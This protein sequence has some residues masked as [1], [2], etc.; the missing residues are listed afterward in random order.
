MQAVSPPVQEALKGTRISGLS[1]QDAVMIRVGLQGVAGLSLCLKT[2]VLAEHYHEHLGAHGN[3]EKPDNDSGLDVAVCTLLGR[4][5]A[6]LLLGIS[7]N[8][9]D[10][11]A[12]RDFVV[13]LREKLCDKAEPSDVMDCFCFHVDLTAGDGLAY[14]DAC[15]AALSKLPNVVAG[16]SAR[17]QANKYKG[18]L[19]I[20]DKVFG[21]VYAFLDGP[22]LAAWMA[23]LNQVTVGA[24]DRALFLED[25]RDTMWG[26]KGTT[27]HRLARNAL[28]LPDDGGENNAHCLANRMQQASAGFTV[29]TQALVD[30]YTQRAPANALQALPALQID[31]A[32]CLEGSKNLFA[33]RG[34]QLAID[35]NVGATNVFSVTLG[36]R[37]DA[38]KY[39][40]EQTKRQD[41]AYRIPSHDASERVWHDWMQKIRSLPQQFEIDAAT[42]I[43]YTANH[44]PEHDRIM[45]GWREQMVKLHQSRQRVTL[46]DFFAHVRRA[47]FSSPN[48]RRDAAKQLTS[49]HAMT[50]T[51]PDCHAFVLAVQQMF[52]RM[53]P[54]EATEEPEPMSMRDAV[55]HLHKVLAEVQQAPY[56]RRPTDFQKAW[57][58]STLD[59]R[60]LYE[61]HLMHVTAAQPHLYLKE[62]YKA[63]GTART[64]Y[65]QMSSITAAPAPQPHQVVNAAA[66]QLGVSSK[67]LR[68][69]QTANTNV[70]ALYPDEAQPSRKNAGRGKKRERDNSAAATGRP[71]V[72]GGGTRTGYSSDNKRQSFQRTTLPESFV[73][74]EH[75]LPRHLNIV[76]LARCLN[77][78]HGNLEQHL[79]AMAAVQRQ[80]P[81]VAVCAM[82]LSTGHFCAAGERKQKCASYTLRRLIFN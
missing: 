25:V 37:S 76:A 70:S 52:A 58:G 23:A 18:V 27:L 61:Q 43:Q 69:L 54:T 40:L 16:P 33:A 39:L 65:V 82:C 62:V 48:Q 3:V 21:I 32:V 77:I 14:V 75:K 51:Y 11:A 29:L 55:V 59:L 64:Y 5:S 41:S 46:E 6:H 78:N 19:H 60:Q 15:V 49:L 67:K 73:K 38:C 9:A 13:W 26:S 42:I 36:S 4:V 57:S 74:G 34:Q 28:D 8:L 17:L 31:W 50:K 22:V 30:W 81:G 44:L 47:L 71:Y 56:S 20:T 80:N 2:D 66:A 7:Q 53:Y 72:S 10:D 68:K 1:K 12:R 45:Y 63:L 35:V 24:A 79:E